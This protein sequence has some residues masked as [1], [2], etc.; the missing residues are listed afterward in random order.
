MHY[1]IKLKTLI[2]LAFLTKVPGWRMRFLTAEISKILKEN[3]LILLPK[4]DTQIEEIN[5]H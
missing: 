2:N 4:D 3:D 5:E 1:K